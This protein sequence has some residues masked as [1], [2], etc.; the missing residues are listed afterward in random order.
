MWKISDGTYRFQTTNSNVS[1]KLKKIQKI[2][3]ISFGMNSFNEIYQ[4]K[5]ENIDIAKQI[6]KDVTGNEIYRSG[7]GFLAKEQMGLKL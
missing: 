3:L 1:K 4:I 6:L 2:E 7:E 5:L